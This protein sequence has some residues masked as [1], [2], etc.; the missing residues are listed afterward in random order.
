M[1]C[2]ILRYFQRRRMRYVCFIQ[3]I[4]GYVIGGA[5]YLSLRDAI[6]RRMLL[7]MF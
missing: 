2:N 5:E 1:I 6:A 4:G 7:T 3:Q